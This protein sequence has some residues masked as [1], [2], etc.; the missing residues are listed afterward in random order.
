MPDAS[1][2]SQTSDDTRKT[3]FSAESLST[4]S[5]KLKEVSLQKGDWNLQYWKMTGCTKFSLTLRC[6]EYIMLRASVLSNFFREDVLAVLLCRHT[7]LMS[8]LILYI[9]SD[10]NNNTND[11]KNK[12][13]NNNKFNK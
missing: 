13:N 11:Y 10:V 9:F 1:S 12:N 4:A 8:C 3:T 7:I 2:P 6:L 5:Q